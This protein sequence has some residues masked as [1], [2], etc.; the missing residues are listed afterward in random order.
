MTNITRVMTTTD[1][2]TDN[3]SNASN[4][5]TNYHSYDNMTDNTYGI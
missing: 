3:Y 1:T 5:N 2:D 4:D